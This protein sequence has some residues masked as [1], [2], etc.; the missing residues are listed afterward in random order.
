ML[1]YKGP[2]KVHC[3]LSYA[4]MEC[5]ATRL[6]QT[7][8]MWPAGHFS[9]FIRAAVRSLNYYRNVFP[10]KTRKYI[11]ALCGLKKSIPCEAAM[12]R[13]DFGKSITLLNCK[14]VETF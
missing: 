3:G 1:K 13:L 2:L 9:T 10:N 4:K 11:K 7:A 8:P 6:K 12:S 14:N 5:E